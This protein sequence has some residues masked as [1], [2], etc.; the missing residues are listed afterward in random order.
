MLR[1]LSGC[2]A[3]LC[4][5]ATARRVS[6]DSPVRLRRG[7]AWL[8][9]LLKVFPSLSSEKQI[10]RDLQAL[11]LKCL[12]AEL[13]SF[14]DSAATQEAKAQLFALQLEGVAGPGN[15]FTPIG[16]LLA[17]NDVSSRL[18]RRLRFATLLATDSKASSAS[19]RA[20]EAP[21]ILA[22]ADRRR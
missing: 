13:Q 16:R 7:W 2:F 6:P 14:C 4:L 15:R 18:K 10:C 5:A 19:K 21:V 17:L 9:W 8:N 12:S 11:H 22:G 1:L 3:I 20:V